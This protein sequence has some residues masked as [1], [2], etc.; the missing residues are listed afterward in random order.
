MFK[1]ISSLLSKYRA[2][3]HNLA[4]LDKIRAE[5]PTCRILSAS[6]HSVKL[7]ENIAI[8]NR[9][10]I[11]QVS[12]GNFSY[13]SNDT[14]LFNVNVGNFCSIGPYVQVG[15]AP[16]PTKTFV[17]TY[18]AFYSN[19][20]SGCPLT[21]RNNKIFDD[22]TPKTIVGHDV[23]IGANVIIPG[24]VNVGHGAIIAAGSVVVKDVP[25]YSIVG[26]NPARVIRYRFSDEQ[27]TLLLKSSWWHWDIE[28][29][30]KNV[31]HFSD[32]ENFCLM[33]EKLSR[34]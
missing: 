28:S 8:L 5:N 6:L 15:L 29:I 23:W 3:T 14:R 31:D 4:L 13:V 33:T 16:H 21:L 19:E 20:N 1:F 7:G 34:E 9:A 22:T 12:I 18:P 10:S 2:T 24:G 30:K 26:G 32:I 11:N 17:S 25:P 27:I